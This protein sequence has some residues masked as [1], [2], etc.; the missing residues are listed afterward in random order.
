MFSFLA[1][2]ARL[3][4]G[5]A[6]LFLVAALLAFWAMPVANQ[7]VI[8]SSTHPYQAVLLLLSAEANVPRTQH[9]GAPIH[10]E[11]ETAAPDE[12]PLLSTA[13]SHCGAFQT[14]NS[15]ETPGRLRASRTHDL[16]AYAVAQL[17]GVS[18]NVRLN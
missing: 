4:R 18:T 8:A 7:S 6:S 10:L 2:L 3:K 15:P 13:T 17:S 12:T 5:D 16:S 14:P 11:V 9:L 1:Q